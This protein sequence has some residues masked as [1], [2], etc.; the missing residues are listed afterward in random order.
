MS[1]QIIVE[2]CSPTLAGLK[3]GNLF[4]CEYN[5]KKEV[6]DY[7][8]RLNVLLCKKGIRIVPVKYYEKRVVLYLYRPNLLHRD[9]NNGIA[10]DVIETLG[11]DSENTEYCVAC[12]A[13]RMKENATHDNFPHEVGFFLGYPP[14]DVVGFMKHN[15]KECKCVGCWKVYGDVESANKKFA[16]YKKCTKRFLYRYKE[17]A[18]LEQLTVKVTYKNGVRLCSL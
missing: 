7:L 5:S 14:E 18:S 6:R 15:A 9:L 17:G 12:L 13:R 3:T 4:S 11:Y 8:R 1:D 2:N 10:K 16:V